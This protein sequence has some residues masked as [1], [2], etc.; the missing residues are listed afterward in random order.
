LYASASIASHAVTKSPPPAST[1]DVSRSPSS[2][3]TAGTPARITT[4]N[5]ARSVRPKSSAVTT[6]GGGCS[7]AP[8]DSARST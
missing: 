6:R 8:A 2:A 3:D 4:S 7:A 5:V 1:S